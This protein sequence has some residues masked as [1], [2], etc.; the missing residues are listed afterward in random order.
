[1]T[2]YFKILIK[3]AAVIFLIDLFW[4]GTAGI[5]ARSMTETIQ[6]QPVSI[7]YIGAI[8]VY[9]LLAYM[10]LE[11]RSYKQAFLYGVCIYGVYDFTNF[12]LFENYDW[13]FAIADMIWGGVLLASSRYLIQAF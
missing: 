6:G 5:F 2:P 4:I 11:T 8:I 1:M 3:T 13:K 12:S 9:F 10:L 7:R